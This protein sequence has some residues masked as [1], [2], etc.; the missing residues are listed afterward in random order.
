MGLFLILS[1][2]PYRDS[3]FTIVALVVFFAIAIGYALFE[4]RGMVFGPTIDIIGDTSEVHS[5]NILIQGR[6]SRISSLSMNGE[7]VQVTEDGRF[8]E[9]YVLAVGYNRI[10]LDAKDQYG[11]SRQRVLEIMY[12]P[13]GQNAAGGLPSL[14]T[15]LTPT[16][17][18]TQTPS[19]TSTVAPQTQ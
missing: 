3:R 9:P 5:Q 14:R 16:A 18:T 8:S 10:V 1:M 6:A 4:S 13:T 15:E 11:R 2:L 7:Q 17:T 19:S 12:T